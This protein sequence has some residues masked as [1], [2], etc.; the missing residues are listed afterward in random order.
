MKP[1]LRVNQAAFASALAMYLNNSKKD[2][3]QVLNQKSYWII[4]GAAKRTKIADKSK[5]SRHLKWNKKSSKRLFFLARKKNKSIKTEEQ[6]K[7]YIK[8]LSAARRRSVAYIKACWTTPLAGFKRHGRVKGK[9]RIPGATQRG[10]KKGRFK[11]ARPAWKSSA[12]FTNSAGASPNSDKKAGGQ[13]NSQAEAAKKYGKPALAVAF[14][15]EKASML[16]YLKKK[17]AGSAIR[18]GVGRR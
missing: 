2:I 3:T 7:E 15:K 10:R 9:S 1:S 12:T 4:L 17:M 5:I 18:Q 16:A 6:A 11:I 14:A 13:K 8:K